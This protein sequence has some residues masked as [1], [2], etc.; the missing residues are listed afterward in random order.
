MGTFS[1]D[2]NYYIQSQEAVKRIHSE[3]KMLSDNRSRH[4]ERLKKELSTKKL[5]DEE[6]KRI[7]EKFTRP[8]P[9]EY[10][11]HVYKIPQNKIKDERHQKFKTFKVIKSK[12]DS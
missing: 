3:F 12:G 9:K 5:R 8:K 11:R 4:V 1:E 6:D 10:T 2:G 7:K